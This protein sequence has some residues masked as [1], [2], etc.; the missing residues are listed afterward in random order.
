M[1]PKALSPQDKIKAI[2]FQNDAFRS[3]MG[4]SKN[5]YPSIR[6]KCVFS[7]D[8]SYLPKEQIVEIL[9]RT[10]DFNGFDKFIDPTGEHKKGR[11]Y[12]SA[13]NKDVVWKIHYYKWATDKI[14]SPDPSDTSITYRHLRI[15]LEP[16]LK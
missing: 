16:R 15:T 5:Y 3:Q 10:R 4:S 13:I 1:N 12:Y 14:P 6:G 7:M 8:I 2:A 11:F 9:N